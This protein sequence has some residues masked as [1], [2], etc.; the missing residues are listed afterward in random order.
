MVWACL[1]VGDPLRVDAV[2]DLDGWGLGAG[3]C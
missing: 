3:G 1:T 2:I